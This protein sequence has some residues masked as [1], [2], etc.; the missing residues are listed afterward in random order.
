M[1]MPHHT[2]QQEEGEG[3]IAAD[4]VLL[5][6]DEAPMLCEFKELLESAGYA[7]VIESDAEAALERVLADPR[8]G[9]VITDLRMPRLGGHELI[10]AIR[11]R[12][13]A[14]RRVECVLVTGNAAV[15][16]CIHDLD[17]PILEKPINFDSLFS[18]LQTALAKL[19]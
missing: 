3:R 7:A 2:R 14:G 13:P 8:I 11:E 17:V 16:S 15:Q 19:A 1:D 9:V 4:L 18:T 12:L 10:L 6:D 5:V